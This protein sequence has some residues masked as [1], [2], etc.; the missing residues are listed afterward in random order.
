[1]IAL[2][3][4]WAAWV[5][6]RIGGGCTSLVRKATGYPLF[7]PEPAGLAGV[8][9]LTA[10]GFG[11][12]RSLVQPRSDSLRAGSSYDLLIRARRSRAIPFWVRA[13]APP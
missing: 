1:V 6:L 7:A 8:T 13:R 10:S 9:S 5:L 4:L 11:V 12:P 3:R 2:A